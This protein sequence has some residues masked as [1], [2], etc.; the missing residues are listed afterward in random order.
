MYYATVYVPAH[1]GC[2]PNEYADACAKSNLRNEQE[3]DATEGIA[4]WVQSRP[5]VAEREDDGEWARQ[6]ERHTERRGRA[7]RGTCKG[8]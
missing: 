6:M 1:V 7:R 8:G 3:V 5:R 2:S 4:K